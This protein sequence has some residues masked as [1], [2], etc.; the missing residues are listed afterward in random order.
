MKIRLG[1]DVGSTHTDAVAIDEKE[2]LITAT[3]VQTTPDVTTGIEN[4]VNDI[5]A[6][7][8]EQK[9]YVN[10][11]MLGTTHGLNALLQGKNLA[12]VGVI[13]IGLPAGEGIPPMMDW[14][15]R[16]KKT[17]RPVIRMVRGGHEYTGDEIVE[18]DYSGLKRV[19]KEI[20]ESG[21]DSVAIVSIFSFVNPSHELE[22]AE[23][24][25]GMGYRGNIILSHKIS[26]L[27][28]IERENSTILNAALIPVM[29]R[30][31]VSISS[32]LSKLRLDYIKLFFAQNDGT[33]ANAAFAIKYPVFT[34]LGPISNSIRGAHLLTHRENAIVADVGGTTTNIGV[35]S[36][37]FPRESSEAVYL[38]GVRT[39]FRMP[40]IYSI[41][42]AGG[43]IIDENGSISNLSLGYELTSKGISWGGKYLSASDVVLGIRGESFASAEP[44]R[45]LDIMPRQKLEEIYSNMVRMWTDSVD[46]MKTSK[47]DVTLIVVGGGSFMLPD[48]MNGIS[49][50]IRPKDAQF[51]NAIGAALA[52]VGGSAEKT[53]SY[54]LTPRQKAIQ[55]TVE[56]AK[57]AAIEAGADPSTIEVRDV[58]EVSMPYLPGA[59]V[60]VSVKVVGKATLI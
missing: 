51:A 35:L 49:E 40:D 31:V 8:G 20:I 38:A 26:T 34:V 47:E 55:E 28:L 48:K 41:P 59:S 4:A 43:T 56:E 45:V 19:A 6:K 5:I 27:G 16:L 9:S 17:L 53:F 2:N 12:R 22:A 25:E 11:L 57:K 13:R 37:G 21:V 60:R 7:L 46:R 50:I 58:D 36:K 33:V 30:V 10:A 39:N 3:K 32:L 42:L 23:T 29:E 14:P 24:L 52:K 1:I 18:L 15:L 54:D 44:R